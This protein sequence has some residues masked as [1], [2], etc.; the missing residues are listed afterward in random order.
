MNLKDIFLNIIIL[1]ISIPLY[2]QSDKADPLIEQKNLD[3]LCLEFNTDKCSHLHNYTETYEKYFS[4]IRNSAKRV[5]EI[6]ILSGASHL[7]WQAYFKNA[8]IYGIDIKDCSFLEE[9]GIHTMIADQQKRGDLKKFIDQYGSTFDIIIDDGGHTM[10][11]QQVSLGY[12]FKH[13]KQG[14]YY[15][16]EDIH[17]SLKKYYSGYGVNETGSNTTFAMIVRF[18][19]TGDI[20]SEYMTTEEIN[21]LKLNIEYCNFV[22]ITNSS[23]SMMCIIKKK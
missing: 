22:Y 17:T 8:Q 10:K 6:G 19:T 20:Y 23:H 3:E 21:Y 12:L 18:I 5:F 9:K 1:I 16:I 11:Q 2:C 4:P 13:V 15:I 14:G 7:L